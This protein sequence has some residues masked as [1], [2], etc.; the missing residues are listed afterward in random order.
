MGGL[1]WKCL[2]LSA[3]GL[4]THFNVGVP[5]S[6]SI[7]IWRF[8]RFLGAMLMVSG[9]LPGGLGW[10]LLC[11]WVPNIVSLGPLAGSSVALFYVQTFGSSFLMARC[12]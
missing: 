10:F 1:C 4:A 6:A 5:W 12:G 3:V 2:C 9:G 7:G 8:C 11:R